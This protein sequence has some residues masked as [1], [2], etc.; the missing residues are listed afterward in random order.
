[1]RIL[2]PVTPQKIRIVAGIPRPTENI[3]VNKIKWNKKRRLEPIQ[4][5]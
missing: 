5:T 2:H 3:E 4:G 1:M